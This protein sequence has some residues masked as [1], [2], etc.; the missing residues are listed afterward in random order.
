M[1]KR[2]QDKAQQIE[3]DAHER[4]AP[5]GKVVYTAILEEAEDELQRPSAALFWSGL[6]A[7]LS[8]GFS[9]VAE[10]LLRSHLPERPWTPL[11]AEFGYSVGFLI[12]VLGR[13][14]LFT[15]NTLTPVLPLLQRKDGKT[16]GNVLRLWGVVLAANLLG[17]LAFAWI[18]ARTPA[19]EEHA[20]HAFRQIGH[21]AM[22]HGFGTVLLRAVF[23][24][25]LIASI[26]WLLPFA[27]SARVWVIIFITYL[28]ALAEL[29]HVVAGAAEVFVIALDGEKGWG[30]VLGGYVVPALLGNTIGGVLLVAALNHAQVVAGGGGKAV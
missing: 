14:Q 16:L 12:V 29:S 27:E 20:R 2:G 9:L 4:T 8:M 28:V 6:A 18:A 30:A 19:F 10:G 24:G 15:E 11:V 25:W 21:E 22:R 17:A 5:S 1:S 26:V 7:G 13:Q 23:A 3:E